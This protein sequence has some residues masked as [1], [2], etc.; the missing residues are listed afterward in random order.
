MP[1]LPPLTIADGLRAQL[2]E[3]TWNIIREHVQDVLLVEEE[4]IVSAVNLIMQNMS[5]VVE[6]SGAVTL[7]ALL[8]HANIF[9]GKRVLCLLT[10]GNME[11]EYKGLA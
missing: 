7:A 8:K 6:P 1:Q 9:A 5:L 2:E 4:E 10:G 3:R 11:L